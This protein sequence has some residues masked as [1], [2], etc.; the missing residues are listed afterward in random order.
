MIT[1]RVQHD[2]IAILHV[3]DSEA[4][5]QLINEQLQRNS[6]L[7]CNVDNSRSLS[8]AKE[9][10]LTQQYDI[11]FLDLSLPD[12]MGINTLEDLRQADNDTPIIVLSGCHDDTIADEIIH[13][14]GQDF[15]NKDDFS[16]KII[17]RTIRYAIERKKT[18][19]ELELLAHYDSLTKLYN[20]AIFMDRLKHALLTSKRFPEETSIVTILLDLDNFKNINDTMG[21]GVG[22]ALLIQVANRLKNCVR[23]SDTV[24]R[25][26]GDEFTILFENIEQLNIITP[27]AKKILSSLSE[28]FLIDGK[29]VFAS[30][31]I[32]VSSSNDA[33]N[34]NADNILKNADIA[35]Y[36]AKSKGGNQIGYFT[37]E[38]QVTAQ[39]RN[40][41]E[42]NLRTAIEEDQLQLAFQPQIDIQTGQIYGAESLVRWQHPQYGLIPPDGFIPALEETGLIIPATE[43]IIKKALSSWE[44]WLEDGTVNQSMQISINIPPQFISQHNAYNSFEEIC[45]D[46]TIKRDK[47]EFELVENAFLDFTPKNLETLKNLKD[48]GFRLAIDD[49]GT[50]YSSLGYLKEFPIDCIK[51]DRTFVKDIIDSPKDEAIAEAMINLCEKL[52]INLIAEGVDSQEKLEKLQELNCKVIQGYYFS[53]PLPADKFSLYTEEYSRNFH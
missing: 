16:L 9:K 36:N 37:R 5:I 20:R 26:G 4:D 8:E 40:N 30:A 38:L 11:V 41:L 23:E 53:K 39:I 49:F 24:A 6:R 21:H 7:K 31:S 47:I 12:S 32:G 51:L 52:D 45:K 48:S 28:P 33:K 34:I 13:Y 3:E 14:G 22:D 18:E 27:I 46:F 42:K 50:G 35:M 17:D 10:L 15:I 29:P 44:R 25:L 1:D 43:W 19:H 2:H